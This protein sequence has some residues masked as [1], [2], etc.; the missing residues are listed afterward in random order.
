M[1]RHYEVNNPEVVISNEVFKKTIHYS[2]NG[3]TII[4]EAASLIR[5]D[6][7]E[8][9]TIDPEKN[10]WPPK[11]SKLQ[12]LLVPDWVKLFFQSLFANEKLDAPNNEKSSHLIES[13]VADMISQILL[14]MGHCMTYDKT[15]EIETVMAKKNIGSNRAVQYLTV[16]AY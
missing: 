9:C 16:I 14:K 7:K 13:F 2:V 11:L 12:Q 8:Q 4:Q 6:T 15:F 1:F 5:E 10:S 3:N